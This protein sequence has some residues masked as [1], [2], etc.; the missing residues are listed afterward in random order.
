MADFTFFSFRGVIAPLAMNL[1]K[2]LVSFF[3]TVWS[4]ESGVGA[5]RRLRSAFC[6]G[7]PEPVEDGCIGAVARAEQERRTSRVMC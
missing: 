5:N 7:L 3:K 6:H 4:R 2:S 1:I